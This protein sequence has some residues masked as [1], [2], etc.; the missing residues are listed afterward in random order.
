MP[1]EDFEV[2]RNTH[3][4]DDCRIS[5]STS[6][7]R[8]VGLPQ[9]RPLLDV[10]A[11]TFSKDYVKLKVQE[12]YRRYSNIALTLGPSPHNYYIPTCLSQ[13][14]HHYDRFFLHKGYSP[15]SPTSATT[16][17]GREVV[18]TGLIYRRV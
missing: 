4:S 1:Y 18:T 10:P 14:Y 3:L 16:K 12:L 5:I 2:N 17:I 13:F 7:A 9:R 11:A 15:Q 6:A 8:L